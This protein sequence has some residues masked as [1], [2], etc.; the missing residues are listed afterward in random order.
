MK[1]FD[2]S[3]IYISVS[4]TFSLPDPLEMVKMIADPLNQNKIFIFYNTIVFSINVCRPPLVHVQTPR[5]PRITVWKTLIYIVH[6]FYC[7][8]YTF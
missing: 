3:Y 7:I 6:I 1:T 4:Q 8:N 2:K 5:G